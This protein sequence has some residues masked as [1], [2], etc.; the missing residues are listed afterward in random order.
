MKQ[1]GLL[2]LILTGAVAVS[3]L[4]IPPPL[5]G[6]LLSVTPSFSA[7]VRAYRTAAVERGDIVATVQAA[8]TLT[9]S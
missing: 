1:L 9:L 3:S 4:R 8:G 2:L 7:D 6:P 5:F